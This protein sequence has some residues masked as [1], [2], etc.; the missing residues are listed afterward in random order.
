MY[1][2]VEKTHTILKFFVARLCIF[3]DLTKSQ[4][5][6]IVGQKKDHLS[7]ED[8][9]FWIGYQ[10]IAVDSTLSIDLVILKK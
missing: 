2:F 9:L 10:E 8:S 6:G 1:A 3:L 4:T 7:N 5:A